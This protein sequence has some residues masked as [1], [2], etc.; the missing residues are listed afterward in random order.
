MKLNVSKNNLR[1]TKTVDREPLILTQIWPIIGKN[2]AYNILPSYVVH[3]KFRF[4][5]QHE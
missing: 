5:S 2:Y 1:I 3:C 4:V